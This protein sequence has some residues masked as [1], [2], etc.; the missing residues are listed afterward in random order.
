MRHAACILFFFIL[1]PFLVLSCKTVDN[2][3][4]FK[5]IKNVNFFILKTLYLKLIQVPILF[6]K[7]KEKSN[8]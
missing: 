5:M 4:N 1:M 7:R 2:M 8:I 3:N 6:I